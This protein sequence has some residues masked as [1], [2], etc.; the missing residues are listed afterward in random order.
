MIEPTDT[1]D[2]TVEPGDESLGDEG[3][4]PAAL[5][6]ATPLRVAG[7]LAT[8]LGA[9]MMGGG[10]LLHW[11]TVHD[12]NDINGGLDLNFKG[13][14]VRNGKM[15][16]GAA[17][18]LLV[19]LV[20]LRAMRSRPAQEAA[21]T[22]MILASLVGLLY[23]GAFLVDGGHRYF[24]LPSDIGTLGL[25]VLLTLAGAVVALLGAILDLAWS[26]SPH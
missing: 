4:S 21:A 14:D 13:I 23:A 5:S 9:A 18:V 16:L 20:V 26:V 11:V 24:L 17:A 15:A 12:P 3:P 6:A 22:V 10:A 1:A 7:F 2:P 25:G 8:V 19:G